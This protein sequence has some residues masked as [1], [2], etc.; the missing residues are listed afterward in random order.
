MAESPLAGSKGEQGRVFGTGVVSWKLP[1]GR[2]PAG[3]FLIRI[4]L[5]FARPEKARDRE[6]GCALIWQAVS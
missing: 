4:S 1:S 6:A 5:V 3:S 2:Q